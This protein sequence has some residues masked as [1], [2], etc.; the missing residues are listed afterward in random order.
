MADRPMLIRMICGA[1]ALLAAAAAPSS[2]QIPS[3][4]TEASRVRVTMADSRTIMGTVVR[5]RDDTLTLA[6][7]SGGLERIPW[8]AVRAIEATRGRAGR[9]GRY[10]GGGAII[11][12]TVGVGAVIGCDDSDGFI[13]SCSS[14]APALIGAGMLLGAVVGAVVGASGPERWERLPIRAGVGAVPTSDGVRPY[15]VVSRP[16]RLPG[17]Y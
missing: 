9:I 13:I 14:M 8:N 17:S 1:L 5:L 12:I 16:L 6:T 15:L 3:A 7:R 2:A 11:G 4:L 10:A